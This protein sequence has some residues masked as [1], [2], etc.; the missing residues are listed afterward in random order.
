MSHRAEEERTAATNRPELLVLTTRD[1]PSQVI[2]TI[3]PE[4]GS[5]TS[6]VTLPLSRR[7]WATATAGRRPTDAA[8]VIARATLAAHPGTPNWTIGGEDWTS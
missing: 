7:V 5:P 8:S 2:V 1:S 3:A 4:T 6:S